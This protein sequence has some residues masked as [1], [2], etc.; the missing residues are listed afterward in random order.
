[1]EIQEVA[2]LRVLL[3]LVCYRLQVE[4]LTLRCAGST[5]IRVLFNEPWLTQVS[6]MRLKGDLP[7]D[8][9]SNTLSCLVGEHCN[10]G[11]A[12]SDDL[13]GFKEAV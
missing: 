5:Q 12:C 9:E 11:L 4:E 2:A 10:G 1:M 8:R 7:T 13:T 3:W 6:H